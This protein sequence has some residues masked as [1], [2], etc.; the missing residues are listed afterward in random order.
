MKPKKR[1]K[2]LRPKKIVTSGSKIKTYIER[3]TTM[4]EI[5][6]SENLSLVKNKK[7]KFKSGPK[8]G[9]G[10]EVKTSHSAVKHGSSNGPK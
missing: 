2:Q 10:G 7:P 9:P 8:L 1:P 5:N 3:S 6:A 4:K